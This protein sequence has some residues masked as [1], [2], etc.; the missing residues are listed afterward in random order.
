MPGCNRVTVKTRLF[1]LIS[2]TVVVLDQMT[3]LLVQDHPNVVRNPGAAF[4]LMKSWTLI[5]IP[6]TLVV[7]IGI[8][9][10]FHKKARIPVLIG[11]GLALILGGAVGNLVDRVRLGYV[12]DFIDLRIWPVFNLADSAITLGALIIL[13]YTLKSKKRCQ[14]TE[15]P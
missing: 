8:I 4:G 10:F 12:I 11:V 3:K 9:R 13:F 6:V 7:S 5:L 14:D 2:F 15:K 1:Y